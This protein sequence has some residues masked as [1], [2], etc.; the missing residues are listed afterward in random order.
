[1]NKKLETAALP[2]QLVVGGASL[3]VGKVF[4]SYQ[5]ALAHA[6]DTG[7][8]YIGKLISV[9]T[10]TTDETTGE[11]LK[12]TVTIY[13][14]EEDKEKGRI[15]TEFSGNVNLED[16]LKRDEIA[17][18]FTY[19]GSVSDSNSLPKEGL[20][21]GDLY[22]VEDANKCVVWNGNDW[23]ELSNLFN[24][25]QLVSADQFAEFAQTYYDDIAD[26]SKTT[27]DL[28]KQ[29]EGKVP[30]MT[31]YS[32]VADNIIAGATAIVDDGNYEK[33]VKAFYKS[34]DGV[35]TPVFD[36]IHEMLKNVSGGEASLEWVD[37]QASKPEPE[38]DPEPEP[39]V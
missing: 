19:K 20:V 28:L 39:A 16:Y 5:E 25:D 32:L 22:Y 9:I 38:P 10:P 26:L 29:V 12:Q 1:M 11:V 31:G 36:N 37:V 33:I 3:E 23:D 27:S 17:K 34:V 18:S 7:D 8:S 2:M 21:S 24:T 15:L 35:S 4:N 30:K 14:I 6:L 13:V